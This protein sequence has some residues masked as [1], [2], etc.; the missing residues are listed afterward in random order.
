MLQSAVSV[1]Y[2]SIV[3]YLCLMTNIELKRKREAKGLTQK[4]LGLLAGLSTNEGTAR[5]AIARYE[6]GTVRIP[7]WRVIPLQNALKTG[8]PPKTE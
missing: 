3:Y 6:L 4:E 2:Y 1:A 8:K 7:S 5:N